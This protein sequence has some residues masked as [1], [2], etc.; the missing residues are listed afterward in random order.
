MKSLTH[1]YK[2][3]GFVKQRFTIRICCKCHQSIAIGRVLSRNICLGGS[4]RED[5]L[6]GGGVWGF[7]PENFEFHFARNEIQS[8]IRFTLGGKVEGLGGKLGSLSFPLDRTLHCVVCVC[9][10]LCVRQ[11]DGSSCVYIVQCVCVCV[12]LC[13]CVCAC[14]C[15]CVCVCIQSSVCVCV[16]VCVCVTVCIQ[17]SVCVC[18]CVTVCV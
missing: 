6:V 4:S 11:I 14:H 5:R 9:V 8:N 1:M 17:S 10:S 7:S 13:V 2:Q 18:V 3:V 15:V 12:S 16:C